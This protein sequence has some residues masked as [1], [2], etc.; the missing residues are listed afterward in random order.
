MNWLGN[1]RIALYSVFGAAL[2][3][4]TGLYMVI[5]LAGLQGIPQELLEA[6]RIDGANAW[7]AFRH[8]TIP[9]LRQTFIIV[10]TLATVN[11]L[12][13]FDLI[14]GMTGG[15]PANKTQILASWSYFK[16][17]NIN[18]YGQGMAVSVLLL[19]ITLAII[20]PYLTWTARE[21]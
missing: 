5:F 1:Y 7:H 6:A 21:D 2:W 8:I 11:A 12:R 19:G 14:F 4:G 3:R 9:S 10:A 17:F 13:A 18:N 20:V 15:G 16:S